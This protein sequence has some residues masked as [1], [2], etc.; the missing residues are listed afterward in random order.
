MDS[1]AQHLLNLARTTPSAGERE[2]AWAA[3]GSCSAS[4][5]PT[6][7][8]KPSRHSPRP[9]EPHSKPPRSKQMLPKRLGSAGSSLLNRHRYHLNSRKIDNPA[10]PLLQSSKNLTKKSRYSPAPFSSGEYRFHPVPLHRLR[11]HYVTISIRY[12]IDWEVLS[13]ED[14]TNFDRALRR[15]R[16]RRRGAKRICHYCSQEYL[17]RADA[18]YCSTRCRVAAHRARRRAS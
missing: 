1:K 3:A 7:P 2:A 15:E 17:G 13:D 18:Q 16:L 4:T 5:W 8:A 12:M 11:I 10:D 14:I 6:C 9:N